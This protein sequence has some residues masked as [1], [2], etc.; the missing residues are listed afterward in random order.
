MKGPEPMTS[1]G[2]IG[3]AGSACATRAGMISI[4]ERLG[5]ASVSRT[6]PKGSLSTSRKVRASSASIEA[7]AGA[8]RSP[9][10]SRRMKRRTEATQSSAVTGAPSCHCRPSR[11]RNV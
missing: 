5:L 4:G 1:S 6:M 8:R 3:W 2:L 7:T 9:V 10:G 11:S